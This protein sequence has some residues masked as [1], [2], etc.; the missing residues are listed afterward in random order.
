MFAE[1]GS[2]RRLYVSGCRGVAA[3]TVVVRVERPVGVGGDLDRSALGQR[4]YKG[5]DEVARPVRQHDVVV[6]HVPDVADEAVE[7]PDGC[8]SPQNSKS[9][10]RLIRDARVWNLDSDR[11]GARRGGAPVSR[12]S[13]LPPNE[14]RPETGGFEAS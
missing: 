14:I 8:A 10:H 6:V 2:K 1:G 4:V 12:T 9:T 3:L 11:G 5:R 13:M 7:V